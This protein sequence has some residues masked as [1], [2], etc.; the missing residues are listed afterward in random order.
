M[1]SKVTVDDQTQKEM[2]YK[3]ISEWDEF[4]II[5]AKEYYHEERDF[6][7]NILEKKSTFTS[8]IIGKETNQ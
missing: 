8:L 5:Y 3:A 4:K 6:E 1:K 7:P 2:I